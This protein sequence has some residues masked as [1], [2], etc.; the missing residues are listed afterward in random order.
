MPITSPFIFNSAPP[1]LPG[2]MAA[3]VWSRCL[4]VSSSAW[5]SRFRALT[6]PTVTDCPY[7][8]A[9][10]MAI[11]PWPTFKASES[12]IVAT[13]IRLI[14]SAGISLSFTA[15]TA[16]SESESVPLMAAVTGS[17]SIKVTV[18]SLESSTTWLFVTIRSSSSFCPTIIPEPLLGTSMVW[19]G[20]NQVCCWRS[21]V[22]LMATTDGI[23]FSTIEETSVWIA[24]V[25]GAPPF[26]EVPPEA[27]FPSVSA[28]A[29]VT[30]SDVLSVV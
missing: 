3:S 17:L 19:L 12:P 11:T 22:L 16:R 2:L 18:S 13:L 29:T 6:Y 10:P 7:P 28:W 23:A 26:P 9:F 21:M 27:E 8:N 1:L 25:T 20:P 4:V 15:I 5:T 24:G 30:G 14:V